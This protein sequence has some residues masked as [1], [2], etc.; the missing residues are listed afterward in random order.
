MVIISVFLT[1]FKILHE[2][3]WKLGRLSYLIILHLT[4]IYSVL[5]IYL[6]QVM[7][8][9]FYFPFSTGFNLV[10]ALLLYGQGIRSNI[11]SYTY[12]K[13]NFQP[14][15]QPLIRIRSAR[16]KKVLLKKKRTKNIFK[17]KR[18]KNI[19]KKK[20]KKVLFKKKRITRMVQ[21]WTDALNWSNYLFHT[22]LLTI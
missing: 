19:F 7:N 10:R 14:I 6:D 3:L 15:S 1:Y 8:Q 17:K 11:N 9:L 5:A 21:M 20:R 13:A 2:N 16:W 22:F 4:I 12:T 18:K